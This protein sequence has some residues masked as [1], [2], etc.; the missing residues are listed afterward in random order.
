MKKKN[1][2]KPEKPEEKKDRLEIQTR[3]IFFICIAAV[4]VFLIIYFLHD[5]IGAIK[6]NDYVFHRAKVG[7]EN[8]WEANVSPIING[9][10]FL[11][12]SPLELEKIPANITGGI[13]ND[14]II[15]VTP[16][17]SNCSSKRVATNVLGQFLSYFGVKIKF[18]LN[19]TTDSDPKF[20][21]GLETNKNCMDALKK[22]VFFLEKSSSNETKIYRDKVYKNCIIIEYEDCDVM[23]GVEAFIIHEIAQIKENQKK[24]AE[25]NNSTNN[26]LQN[27]SFPANSSNKS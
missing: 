22:T 1:Q 11:R 8:G 17:I 4:A 27:I 20:F 7:Q 21:A 23:K 6:W 18:A 12:N 25:K 3:W 24:I 2:K 10:L 15:V 5:S 9:G 19:E 14:A 16:E 13:Y 26:S